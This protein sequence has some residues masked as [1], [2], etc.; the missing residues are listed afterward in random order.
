VLIGYLLKGHDLIV[1]VRSAGGNEGLA[2]ILNT[3]MRVGFSI[4]AVLILFETVREAYKL[5]ERGRL[6]G[7]WSPR[8]DC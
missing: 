3:T 5:I 7:T 4:A 1:A 6:S 2:T 8:Q